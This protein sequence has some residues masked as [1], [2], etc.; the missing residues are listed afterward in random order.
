MA[1]CACRSNQIKKINCVCCSEVASTFAFRFEYFADLKSKFTANRCHIF[2]VTR[3]NEYWLVA[4]W[5]TQVCF[6][7]SSS[8]SL[9][10][11]THRG[12]LFHHLFH[13]LSSSFILCA[14]F[15][16]SFIPSFF[17]SV[18]S[19][20]FVVVVS[21]LVIFERARRGRPLKLG[22]SSPFVIVA[23]NIVLPIISFAFFHHKT[24]TLSYKQ[25]HTR[26]RA[27]ALRVEIGKKAPRK[28]NLRQTNQ[29]QR[30]KR[31]SNTQNEKKKMCVCV[32]TYIFVGGDIE[33]N[34]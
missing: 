4:E 20:F 17:R 29:Q 9:W 12:Y 6:G 5:T 14:F 2:V 13:F 3:L 22:H 8:S 10:W 31:E 24:F 21:V 18:S 30:N 28:R 11:C 1:W 34:I 26:A 23:A 33:K 25:T 7:V 16:L 27:R 15:R 19:L 32:C